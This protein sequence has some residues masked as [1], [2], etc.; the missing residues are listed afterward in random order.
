MWI[1]S[2]CISPLFLPHLS[3]N[4]MRSKGLWLI[5]MINWIWAHPKYW[6]HWF[7]G[8]HHPG[9]LGQAPSRIQR[10]LRARKTSQ[11]GKEPRPAGNAL[12][13]VP[14]SGLKPTL[15][16]SKGLEANSVTWRSWVGFW[17]SPEHQGRIPTIPA[18]LRC[19]SNSKREETKCLSLKSCSASPRCDRCGPGGRGSVSRG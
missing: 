2:G 15:N 9:G 10:H 13:E 3:L 8:C 7:G 16:F 17:G 12:R 18:S 6:E 19:L 1:L 14:I 5:K 11:A 4:L